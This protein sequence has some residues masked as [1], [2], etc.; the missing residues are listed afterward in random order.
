MADGTI[1]NFHAAG[2]SASFKFIQKIT[3][4]TAVNGRKNVEIMVASKYLSNF[5]RTLE[6][7]LTN[8]KINIILTLS[9]KC[10][11]SNETKVTT[12]AITD[13]KAL[14]SSCNF[15]SCNSLNN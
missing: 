6:M 8:F 11:L 12:F 9:K 10:V 7:S 2:N 1:A 14:C 5:W 4:V 13:P 15:I 3:G